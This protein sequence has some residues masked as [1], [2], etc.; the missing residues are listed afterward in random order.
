MAV[1]EKHVARVPPDTDMAG[2]AGLPTA[3]LAVMQALEPYVSYHVASRPFAGPQG[4]KILIHG[5]SGGLG[6]GES[7]TPIDVIDGDS[8]GCA[9]TF[10]IQYCKNVLH[11]TVVS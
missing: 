11:M 7:D 3:A 8:D 6:E 10:A 5:G 9:G 2:V 4:Q 1:N